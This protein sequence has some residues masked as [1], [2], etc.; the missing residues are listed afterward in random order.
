[1]LKACYEGYTEIVELLLELRHIAVTVTV[2]L[3]DKHHQINLEK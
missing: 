2:N 3:K 1:M